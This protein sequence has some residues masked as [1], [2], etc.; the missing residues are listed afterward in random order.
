MTS[1]SGNI[2][3]S[4]YYYSIPHS[5]PGPSLLAC[6]A[7]ISY[8]A[9]LST[10]FTFNSTIESINSTSAYI[11]IQT[12]STTYFRSL[13][14]HYLITTHP[15]IQIKN[16]C[17]YTTDLFTGSG[18]RSQYFS[19]ATTTFNGAYLTLVTVITGMKISNTQGEYFHLQVESFADSLPLVRTRIRTEEY[20]LVEWTC[21]AVIVYNPKTTLVGEFYFRATSQVSNSL[22]LSL[23]TAIDPAYQIYNSMFFGLSLLQMSMTLT[24]SQIFFM[25]SGSLTPLSSPNIN[26]NQLLL[27]L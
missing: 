22:G 9:V 12:Y 5:N 20:N 17:Y 3:Y 4:S 25:D 24:D 1:F 8:D 26:Q 11:M 21:L 18:A 16:L 19:N 2:S 7:L 27:Y 14:Y 23:V 10:T 13:S 6:L 15:T